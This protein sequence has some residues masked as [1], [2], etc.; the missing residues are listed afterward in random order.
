MRRLAQWLVHHPRDREA[1]GGG[2][3]GDLTAPDAT[4]TGVPEVVRSGTGYEG[5]RPDASGR[6]L[7]QRDGAAGRDD[8]V[9]L[10]DVS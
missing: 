3:S 4:V 5:A 10:V 9:V 1:G 2:C 6:G 7:G 8:T